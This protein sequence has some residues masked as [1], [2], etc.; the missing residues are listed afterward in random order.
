MPVKGNHAAEVILDK[1]EFSAT[2]KG[3]TCLEKSFYINKRWILQRKYK[4]HKPSLPNKII[5]HIRSG[6]SFK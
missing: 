4:N 3:V 1:V 5:A 6:Y 2:D